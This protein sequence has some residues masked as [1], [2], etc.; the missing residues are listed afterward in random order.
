MIRVGIA[1][2]GNL[3]R[4]VECAV[5]AN[6]DMTLVAVFTR[7]DP[8]SVK[9]KTPGAKV[10]HLSDAKAMKDEVDVMVICGGSATDL[11]E[12]TPSLATDFNVIDSFD[13]HANIPVHFANV[14]EAA[15]KGGNVAIISTGWDPGMFSLTRAYAT[16]VLPGGESYTFW[17]RG[18]SQGHSDAIRRIPG[19][20][21]ARQYTVPI[22]KA[23]ERV[24]S[25]EN[26]VLTTREKHLRECYVVV[27]DGADKAEIE[28]AIKTMP[29][30][31]ADYDTTVEFITMEEMKRDHAG[32]PHGGSVIHSGKTGFDGEHSH[33][34]EYKLNLD[35]NPEFTGSVLT[36]YARA[37]Y[38]M[39]QRGEKGCKTVFDVAP[40]DISPYS[41]EYMREHLL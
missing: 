23:L 40:A 31:F 37:A 21:D 9:I 27:E 14:N 19:V 22:E 18:V 15:E 24:R 38:R 36:A 3:G 7:R 34:I 28:K 12:L 16:A 39:S 1:G 17:G 30:C 5:A 41:R 35:S 10:C 26:P 11:P 29:N 2:Y 33:T 8:E 20:V 4:G 32:L 13:N 6:E 25:G